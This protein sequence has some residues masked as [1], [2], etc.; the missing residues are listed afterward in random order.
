MSLTTKEMD[1]LIEKTKELFWLIVTA[2]ISVLTPVQNVLVLLFVAFLFNIATGIIADVHA[3]KAK[4]NL[5][6]AFNAV[7]Q[8]TFYAACVV[9]LDYG[10]RLLNEPEIGI[11]AV[12]WMT[13]IV[14]YFYL[15][16]IFKNAKLIY[17]S[18]LAIK[19]IYE[20][21]STEIFERLKNMVGYKPSKHD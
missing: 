17:P 11:T 4:F 21:L 14:V 13:Y 3:N 5:K 16:N 12:K 1:V 9:F 2:L 7:T 6:K 8:L 10:A 15:T 18:N 20:L 19:F